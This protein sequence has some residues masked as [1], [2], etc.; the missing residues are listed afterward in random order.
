MVRDHI[1]LK[2]GLRRRSNDIVRLLLEGLRDHNP[3][4]QGLRLLTWSFR[5]SFHSCVRD[6]IPLKQGLRPLD[7]IAGLNPRLWFHLFPFI[8]GLPK[9]VSCRDKVGCVFLQKELSCI[10]CCHQEKDIQ[11]SLVLSNCQIARGVNRSNRTWPRFRLNMM[12]KT[13]TSSCLSQ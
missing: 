5:W 13:A 3:L 12:I 4:Q 7:L 8:Q 9:N 6:H 1:P 2:Q 10:M 11:V